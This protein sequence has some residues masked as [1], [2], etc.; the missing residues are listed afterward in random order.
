MGLFGSNK[1]EAWQEFAESMGA[2]FLDLGGFKGVKVCL[3]Y[4]C[5]EI[6][7][8]TYTVS[9]GK[10]STTYTR[11]RAIYAADIDFDIK[12]FKRTVFTKMAKAFGRQY[13]MTGDNAFDEDVAIRSA[14]EKMVNRIFENSRLKEMCLAL[15]RVY[16][17]TK[18]ARGRKETK[19][20]QG[21]KEIYYQ[22][23]GVIKDAEILTLIFGIMITLLDEFEKHAIAKS[24]KP[25]IS[26][27]T[28]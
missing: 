11:V 26:Y 12:F 27:L 2:E 20:V 18:K 24:E 1:K 10:S 14:D 4:K 17:Y 9:T 6:V 21:E 5:W 15:K 7:M 3:Y 22:A 8:D 23:V 28:N 25:K 19:D 16:Y 13:A